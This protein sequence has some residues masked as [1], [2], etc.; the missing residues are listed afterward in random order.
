ME[1]CTLLLETFKAMQAKRKI[2]LIDDDV[3]YQSLV[4]FLFD[5]DTNKELS[6]ECFNNGSEAL[7]PLNQAMSQE[8]NLPGVILLDIN[9][10][11]MGGWE[12]LDYLSEKYNQHVLPFKIFVISSSI[13]LRDRQK[14]LSYSIVEDYITKPISNGELGKIN[15]SFMRA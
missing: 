10:P 7:E 13:S 6:I 9:M 8:R 3:V 4:E 1:P 12:F 15:S 5:I 11:V 2:W 14:A